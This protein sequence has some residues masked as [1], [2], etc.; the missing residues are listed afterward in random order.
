MKVATL[1]IGDELLLGEIVDTN[2]AHIAARLSMRGIRV[3]R[4]LTV[5][6]REPDIGEALLSLAGTS[7]TVIV[8]GGLG[9]TL[10]DLTARAAA[11]ALGRPLVLNEEAL[12]HVRKVG[13][14]LGRG[15]HPLNEKQALFPANSFLIPNPEGTACGFRLVHNG[16]TL[17]FMPGVPAEMALMLD[18]TVIPCIDGERKEPEL[19]ATKVLK[20]FGLSEAEVDAMLTGAIAPDSGVSIAFAV[21]FPEVHVKLRAIGKSARAVGD[22]L[23]SACLGVREKLWG[24]VFGEDRE[25]IDSVVADLFRRNGVT[26]SLA[27]SCTGG[28]VA[29]RITDVP[30]SSVYFI[31]GAVT[32]A[33]AA[34]VRS[35][36]ISRRLLEEEGAVSSATAIA[37]ARGMRRLSGSDI[38]LA[39]TG[40]AGPEG[41]SE[42]KPVG[43]V[44]LALATPAGCQAK[45]YL[46]SGSRDEIRTITAFTAMDW[47]RRHLL[48]L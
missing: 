16:C 18:E 6:D 34:K 13:G 4:H 29:K 44:F 26:L 20:I 17:Y 14:K 21:D 5:G 37:M 9:P 1:S 43:T 19:L 45:G 27:E 3:R 23:D 46:F 7:E 47:L 40:I 39:I 32:Y 24:Y 22:A 48:S 42:E 33:D 31:E 28:L 12:A 36:G 11:K 2:A 25:T 41:G 35:L 8:T 15:V 30:G 10:D 38:A